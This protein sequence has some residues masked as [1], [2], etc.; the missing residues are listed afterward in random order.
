MCHL[1]LVKFNAGKTTEVCNNVPVKDVPKLNDHNY[2]PNNGT[3]LFDAVG[4]A[5][6]DTKESV[7]KSKEK[8]DVLFVVIT[9]G[10][11]NA[12]TQYT[13]EQISQ[14]VIERQKAG[15]TF[16]Y[17]GANQ[18]S[19]KNASSMGYVSAGSVVDFAATSDGVIRGMGMASAATSRYF[20]NRDAYYNAQV[21]SGVDLNSI[22]YTCSDFLKNTADDSLEEGIKSF[23]AKLNKK[24][25][26]S[27]DVKSK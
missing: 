1:T 8:P 22:S 9:D 24:E 2:E 17:L 15:W 11:E 25:K 7:E 12:S 26:K 5:I 4:K 16:A 27:K 19:W 10:D 6:T 18:D 14:L 13:R 21:N 3:P 23:S 20:S